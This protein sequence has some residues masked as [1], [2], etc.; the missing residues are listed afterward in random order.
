MDLLKKL[1]EGNRSDRNR[2]IIDT[3]P[4]YQNE[5]NT[6]INRVNELILSIRDIDT[7]TVT[8]TSSEAMKDQ[9]RGFQVGDT[10]TSVPVQ[11]ILDKILVAYDT[12]YFS[13]FQITGVSSPQ[14]ANYT[15]AAGDYTF[16][17]T[18]AND[19]NIEADSISIRDVTGNSTLASSLA[20]DGSQVITLSEIVLNSHGDSQTYR[21]SC[22]SD[23]GVTFTRDFTVV[24]YLPK[25]YGVGADGLT[26]NQIDRL[27]KSVAAESSSNTINFPIIDDEK[28]YYAY[29]KSWGAMTSILD[30]N[31]FETLSDWTISTVSFLTDSPY[32]KG[33]TTDYYVAV[34]NNLITAPTGFTVTFK[35]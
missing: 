24:S 10:F 5:L 20:N 1:G 14:E 33:S 27:T 15:Y 34:S 26:Y 23:R 18:I 35:H 29:P 31:G 4:V 16:V 12:P 22:V 6:V 2:T 32:Y 3:A 17:W 21:I 8:Y 28:I 25:Y 30:Q 19:S 13:S 11:D 9:F 7:G